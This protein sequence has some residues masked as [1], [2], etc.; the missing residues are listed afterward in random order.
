[1]SGNMS[2]GVR[3]AARV[4]AISISMASTIN[5]YGRIKANRTI[6][7]IGGTPVKKTKD[8]IVEIDK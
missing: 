4:P 3:T 1:M 5:V 6:L 2:I 7:N 8:V